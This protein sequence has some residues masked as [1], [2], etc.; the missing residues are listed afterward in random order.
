MSLFSLS[1]Y[2][3]EIIKNLA[4]CNGKT[5]SN[6]STQNESEYKRVIFVPYYMIFD[7]IGDGLG[8][9]GYIMYVVLLRIL[10]KLV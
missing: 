8:P 10:E 1:V 9:L 5:H 3:I 7:G 2:L 6:N 4:K